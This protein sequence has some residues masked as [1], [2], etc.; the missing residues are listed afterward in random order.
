VLRPQHEPDELLR[1]G[2]GELSFADE[3][4][5]GRRCC[6]QYRCRYR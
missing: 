1:V 5:R 6:R 2:G 3:R 4:R